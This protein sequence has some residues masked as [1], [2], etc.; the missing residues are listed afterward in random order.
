M[1]NQI[2]FINQNSPGT[3]DNFESVGGKSIIIIRA[4]NFTGMTVDIEVAS[5]SDPTVRFEVLPSGNFT[6]NGS[7]M[8]DY[9]PPGIL[10]RAVAASVPGDAELFVQIVQ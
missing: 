1:P 9:L 2:L 7:V 5:S 8:L 10:L 3:S 4:D 6:A